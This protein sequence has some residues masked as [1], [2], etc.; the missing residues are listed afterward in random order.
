M[1]GGI[2]PADVGGQLFVEF[3]KGSDP[4]GIKA[5]EPAIFQ[6]PEVALHLPF[7]GPIPDR[8]V[9]FQS[10]DGTADQG[11]L[12]IFV[13][14]AIIQIELVWNAVRGDRVF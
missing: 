2:V 12:V 13:R 1:D 3:L 4:R 11:E 6:G 8:C 14:R 5:I 9:Q 10:S 7:A